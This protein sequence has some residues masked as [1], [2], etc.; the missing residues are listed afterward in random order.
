MNITLYHNNSEEAALNKSLTTIASKADVR[1]IGTES[2]LSPVFLLSGQTIQNLQ[3]VNYVYVP[4]YGR[5][6]FCRVELTTAGM[7]HLICNID[8]LISF[9]SDILRLDVIIDKTESLNLSNKYVNDNSFINESKE[10]V[11]RYIFNPGS[12]SL[13]GFL[14]EPKHIL[15]CAGGE[16]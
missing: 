6:Y 14:S 13:D 11:Q 1:P 8:P 4:E 5:Y 10:Y 7:Y 9:K 15:I 2:L 12:G 16:G 3:R